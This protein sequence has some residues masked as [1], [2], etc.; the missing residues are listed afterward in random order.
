MTSFWDGRWGSLALGLRLGLRGGIGGR[1]E[2]DGVS[3]VSCVGD[4]GASGLRR[5]GEGVGWDIVGLVR[6]NVWR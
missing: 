1:V 6:A 5:V 4:M 2:D 3:G